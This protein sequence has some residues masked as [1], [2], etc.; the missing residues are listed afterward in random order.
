VALSGDSREMMENDHV[1][2]AYLGRKMAAKG[3][4][5]I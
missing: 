4:Q 1:R 3:Q 5:K 2:K